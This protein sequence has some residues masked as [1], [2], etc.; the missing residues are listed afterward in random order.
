M[1][2]NAANRNELDS[3]FRHSTYYH[4]Y[5]QGYTELKVLRSNGKYKIERFYTAPWKQHALTDR[6]RKKVKRQ[7]LLL[8]AV[9]I[10]VFVMALMM[11]VNSNYTRIAAI[12][13]ML[14]VIGLILTT[15]TVISYA[16]KPVLMTLW[17]Y[18]SS[19]H[20]LQR[21]AKW[22][23]IGV[24]VTMAAKLVS[25]LIYGT[26]SVAGEV[27]S[28]LLLAGAAGAFLWIYTSERD[29]EYEDIPNDTVL[30]QEGGN[31]IW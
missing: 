12:P 31:E 7:Y 2:G 15:V 23:G 21:T 1:K 5:F 27:F 28:Q 8:T 13:G 29:M 6:Q 11:A 30:P 9:G 16:A 18:K 14:T 17:D 3:D 25:A 10:F 22:T 24:G 26:Q 20:R 19:S 4:K